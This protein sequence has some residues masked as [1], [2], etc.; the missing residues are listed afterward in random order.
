MA[1]L[2]RNNPLVLVDP[3]GLCHM[4]ADNVA[5]DD[6]PGDCG[7]GSVTAVAQAP[8]DVMPIFVSLP[9]L[10]SDTQQPV[11]TA[12]PPVVTEVEWRGIQRIRITCAAE[13]ANRS[14]SLKPGTNVGRMARRIVRN[15]AL[16][17]E[18]Q[19]G[20]FGAQL[21]L[22]IVQ[23]AEAIA[24]S[25]RGPVE[26]ARM[27]G[28]MSE[29]VQRGSVVIWR[30]RECRLGRQVNRIYNA[31][32]EG[33]I[34]LIVQDAR[35]RAIQDRFGG[36]YDLEFGALL[37]RV[38]RNSIDLFRVEHGIDAVNHPRRGLVALVGIRLTTALLPL[39][40]CGRK[41]PIFNLRSGFASTDLPAALL[42]LL[43]AHP[44]RIVIAA[45]GGN[46]HEVNGVAA[47]VRLFGS[48]IEWRRNRARLPR[49][50]PRCNAFFEH[51]NDGV[52]SFLPEIAFEAL[53]LRAII[54]CHRR[55]PHQSRLP[56][57]RLRSLILQEAR[58]R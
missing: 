2:V 14:Q 6:E 20:Q 35:A 23:V 8:P 48:R 7:G 45:P 55:L 57:V 26:V 43:V 3:M 46:R 41:L 32:V 53:R 12:P 29:F 13:F 28:P 42:R 30:R 31:I 50:L 33:P 27:A 4:G 24:F 17:C 10:L 39:A 25:Q 5:Y 52:C 38:G 37:R 36:L 22:R 15:G 40:R 11:P 58:H 54:G 19:A 56:V 9:S 44:S 47:T 49:F 51:A 1:I 18:E 34:V 16:G 21:L